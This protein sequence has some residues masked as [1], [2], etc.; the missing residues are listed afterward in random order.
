ML[1][2]CTFGGLTVS[3][4]ESLEDRAVLGKHLLG[5]SVVVGR[6]CHVQPRLEKHCVQ[7]RV[8]LAGCRIAGAL[9]DGLV[10]AC[11]LVH[12]SPVLPVA[13]PEPLGLG[14]LGKRRLH[15]LQHFRGPAWRADAR[16][17]ALD[18]STEVQK[19]I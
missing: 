19:A 11:V 1:A 9:H 13:S 7:V 18:E 8:Y 17:V 10:Q 15:G 16:A 2:N 3:R 6:K 5:A 12:E 14:H 4:T